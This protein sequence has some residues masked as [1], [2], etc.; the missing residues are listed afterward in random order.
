M[1]YLGGKFAVAKQI[2]AFLDS[3]LE[4][5]QPFVDLFAGSCNIVANITKTNNRYA[6][7]IQEDIM[8]TMRAAADGYEFPTTVSKDEYRAM[9]LYGNATDPLYGFMAYGCSFAGKRWGGY[10]PVVLEQGAYPAGASS[11]A[12]KRKGNLLTTTKFSM[13]SYKAFKLP[14]NAIVYCDIPYSNTVKYSGEAGQFNHEEFYAWVINQKHEIFISEYATGDNPLG[15]KIVW[16]KDSLR[17]LRRK[18]GRRVM[19]TEVL[20]HKPAS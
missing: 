13:G 14:E 8:V 9:Q 17:G 20:L 10:A 6:N 19:T 3:R 1:R 18:G 5:D 16:Q 11:R 4:E 2:C 15:L 7:D 12:L